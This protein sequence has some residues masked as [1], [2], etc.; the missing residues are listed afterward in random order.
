[1]ILTGLTLCAPVHPH[2]LP[3]SGR[4]MRVTD[5][6]LEGAIKWRVRVQGPRVLFIS[7]R[8]WKHGDPE[9]QWDTKQPPSLI[10]V[11]RNQVLLYWK[12]EEGD[13][14]EIEKWSASS[15]EPDGKVKK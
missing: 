15:G 5:G 3:T 1:M 14:A 13:I 7:P 4:N 8:G 11:P 6:I 2:G 12:G 10:E 9:S